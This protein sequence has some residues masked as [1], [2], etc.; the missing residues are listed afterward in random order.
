MTSALVREPSVP[1]GAAFIMSD[2]ARL[3]GVAHA[4]THTGF[5]VIPIEGAASWEATVQNSA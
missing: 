4:G 2:V 1:D 3:T 5:R